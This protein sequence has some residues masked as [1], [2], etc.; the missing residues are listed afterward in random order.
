MS[1]DPFGD[2][3]YIVPPAVVSEITV[4]HGGKVMDPQPLA[5]PQERLPLIIRPVDGDQPRTY[6]YRE[7]RIINGQSYYCYHMGDKALFKDDDPKFASYVD[8]LT[9]LDFTP[10]SAKRFQIDR[11]KIL[12]IDWSC[13]CEV[14][15]SPPRT[16]PFVTVKDYKV[17]E[18]VRPVKCKGPLSYKT[19]RTLSLDDLINNPFAPV[20]NRPFHYK[21]SSQR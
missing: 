2:T 19:D 16:E 14:C 7:L 8:V 15:T 1:D 10:S 11:K 18:G 6:T 13:K 9:G 21:P 3:S 5:Q 17:V 20:L 12:E 4:A